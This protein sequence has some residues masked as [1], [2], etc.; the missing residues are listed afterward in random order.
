MNSIRYNPLNMTKRTMVEVPWFKNFFA[1]DSS[2]T[3]AF[4]IYFCNG[5]NT[6]ANIIHTTNMQQSPPILEA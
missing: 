5:I 3:T 6:S 2:I 4:F 1:V